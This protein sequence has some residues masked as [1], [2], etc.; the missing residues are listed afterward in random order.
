M[1]DGYCYRLGNSERIPAQV[2]LT[3]D[4][5]VVLWMAQTHT[6]F[7]LQD[8][9]LSDA[10]GSVPRALHLP[11][12]WVFHA[13]APEQ[14]SAVFALAPVPT[15]V[16]WVDGFERHR[17]WIVGAIAVTLLSVVAFYQFVIPPLVVG[18]SNALPSSVYQAMGQQTLRTLEQLD[19]QASTVPAERQAALM[20]RFNAYV[21]AHE[22]WFSKSQ[23]KLLFRDW[24]GVPNAVTLADGHILITDDLLKLLDHDDEVYAVLLHELGHVHGNH[25]MH[26]VVRASLL[27]IG[28][29]VVVGDASTLANTVV[30]AGTLVANMSYSREMEIEADAF[31]ARQLNAE[32]IGVAPFIRSFEKLESTHERKQPSAEENQPSSISDWFASHPN[33][34]ERI[35]RLRQFEPIMP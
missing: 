30:S 14:L 17:L 25:V 13:Y 12:D 21:Q 24:K 18:V 29:A 22:T 26:S 23:P 28:V 10:I 16:K 1:I 15:W 9:R 3:D 20:Q 11:D 35:R 6:N 8:V 19:V 33:T 31:A 27:S 2:E 5:R 34:E 4:G 32:R 7:S